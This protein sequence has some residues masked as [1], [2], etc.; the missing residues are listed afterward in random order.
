MGA[1]GEFTGDVACLKL[2][3]PA[4]AVCE[5]SSRT[6][7]GRSDADVAKE[8]KVQLQVLQRGGG[9]GGACAQPK[10][11]GLHLGAM[12]VEATLAKAIVKQREIEVQAGRAPRRQGFRVDAQRGSPPPGVEGAQR[13][14]AALNLGGGREILSGAKRGSRIEKIALH[15]PVYKFALGVGRG[16]MRFKQG[17]VPASGAIFGAGGIFARR[18]LE[19]LVNGSEKFIALL[20]TQCGALMAV[21]LSPKGE[22]L[23]G[24]KTQRI[25]LGTIF[26]FDERG[27]HQLQ[28]RGLQR[29]E[30]VEEPGG[31]IAEIGALFE[32]RAH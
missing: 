29:D 21:K 14:L 7:P 16:A 22:D 17:R 5:T 10:R 12:A 8:R 27:F 30:G 1:Q 19:M 4:K 9:E 11:G 2:Q 32:E 6:G 24:A 25:D 31:F 13:A 15:Q 23:G 18:L 28:L 3:R 20:G 26:K